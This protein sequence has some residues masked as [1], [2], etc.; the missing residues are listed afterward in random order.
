MSKTVTE[1][2]VASVHVRTSYNG[3]GVEVRFRDAFYADDFVVV[4]P[5]NVATYMV[6]EVSRHIGVE[7]VVT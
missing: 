3:Q 6:T 2:D 5:K 4:L 7:M 1:M